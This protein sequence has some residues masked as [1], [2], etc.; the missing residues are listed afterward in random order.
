M[1]LGGVEQTKEKYRD[2]AWRFLTVVR[3]LDLQRSW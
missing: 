2:T 3:N 1:K